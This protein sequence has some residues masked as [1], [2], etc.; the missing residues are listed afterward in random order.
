MT[1]PATAT[2]IRVSVVMVL[3]YHTNNQQK[4]NGSPKALRFVS[5]SLCPVAR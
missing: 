3:F 4:I 2:M 1:I 5:Q